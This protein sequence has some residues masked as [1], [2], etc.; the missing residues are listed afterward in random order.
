MMNGISDA[1]RQFFF[2]YSTIALILLP[3]IIIFAIAFVA[4]LI[5]RNAYM[6]SE[7]YASTQT[8]FG[9]VRRDKGLSGEYHICK[10]LSALEGNKRFLYNC[11]IPK[12][13]NTTTE[14]DVIL[15]HSSGIY[16]FESKNYSGWIFGSE[17][18]QQWT[19]TFPNGQKERFYNPIM[20]N[21]THI[22]W[23]MRLLPEFENN[24]FRS[25]IVFS[26]RCELKKIN[27]TSNQHSVVKR[28]HLLRT[29]KET[30]K[31]QILSDD[32]IERVYQ[33]LI[34]FTKV[35]EQVKEAHIDSLS[36]KGG[37]AH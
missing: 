3:A 12:S 6:K 27:V 19:Q 10:K 5:Q 34:P 16:V 28:N 18:S 13:N 24:V 4:H 9:I 35:S 8:P 21:N 29:V 15:L 7:Y 2:S 31:Q 20:Q 1:I 17:S 22:K 23:L 14:I 33:K 30:A 26:E 37:K 36:G 25:V 11:Y 32:E